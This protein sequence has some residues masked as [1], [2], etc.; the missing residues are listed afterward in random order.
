MKERLAIFLPSLRGGGAE[1]AMVTIANGFS[2]RGYLVDI[3]LVNAD[4][5]YLKEVSR[6]VNVVD[7]NSSRVLTSIPGF[8][9]YLRREKPKAIVSALNHI[10]VIAVMACYLAGHSS[11]IIVSER[12]NFSA[13]IK[14]TKSMSAHALRLLMRWTYCRADGI[15]A[16]S[17]GVADDLAL[18]IG[19]HRSSINVVYNPVVNKFMLDMAEHHIEHSWFGRGNPPVILGVG[20]LEPAKGFLTLIKSFAI[21]RK[22][23]C[24]RLVILGEGSLRFQLEG[25]VKRLGLEDQVHL[26]GFIDN[27]YAF[28]K[29]ASLFVL[30]SV[31]EGL[32][33]ALIQAMAC[34]TPV[35]STDCPSGPS[36][37][38]EGGRWGRLVPVNDEVALAEA[39]VAA[40]DEK[41]HPD[42]VQRA[43][44]FSADSA[45]DDYLAVTL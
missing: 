42:V 34:G 22:T 35:V 17:K 41:D 33:N 43:A 15:I 9:N 24:A 16:V 27:P 10:N 37:I 45:I 12:S 44:E 13:S 32:P 8:V 26:A 31:W 6:H 23:Y 7:L 21:L 11:R 14:N 38:L 30:S 39:M 5:P 4:G 19:L 1:R 25:E 20:R 29:Q 40:L 2:L 28:M 36:E 18:A 3:V